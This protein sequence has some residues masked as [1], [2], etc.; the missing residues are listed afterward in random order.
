MRTALQIVGKIVV[1]LAILGVVWHGL[2]YFLF[3]SPTDF[4]KDKPVGNWFWRVMFYTH[5]GLGAVALLVGPLQFWRSF[6]QRYMRWHRQVGKLYVGSILIGSV[7]AFNAAWFAS[8]GRVAALGFASLAVGWF[9]TTYQAYRAARRG[10]LTAHRQWMY[11]SYALT[12]SAVMLRILLPFEVLVIGLPFVY[13]YPI[14]AWACWVPNLFVVELL[15]RRKKEKIAQ[16][17]R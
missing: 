11:R 1:C 7:A 9:S 10:R 17:A 2:A 5:V 13:A 8:T 3:E 4:L 14:V 6:R 15:L 16:I 12:L